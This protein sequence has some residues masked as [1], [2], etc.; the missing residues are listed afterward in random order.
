MKTNS[1]WMPTTVALVLMALVTTM[2]EPAAFGKDPEQSHVQ[3]PAVE[4]VEKVGK[5]V[6]VTTTPLPSRP[7]FMLAQAA[8]SQTQTRAA[9]PQ[10]IRPPETPTARQSTSKSKKWIWIVAAAGAAGAAAL[11]ARGGNTN[12]GPAP[13]IVVGTPIVG[14]PQ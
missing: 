11:V 14:Q 10:A 7:E 9:T 8:V 3:T 6:E 5:S 12:P 1:K 13:T 2:L 4:N